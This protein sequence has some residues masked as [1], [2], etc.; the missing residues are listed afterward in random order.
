MTFDKVEIVFF[1]IYSCYREESGDKNGSKKL[2]KLHNQIRGDGGCT[3]NHRIQDA[4]GK[5]G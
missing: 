2:T 1:K 3:I 5:W 4:F